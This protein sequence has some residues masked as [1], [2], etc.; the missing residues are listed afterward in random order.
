M[1]FARAHW[2]LLAII[3]E[4]SG[5]LST[6][7]KSILPTFLKKWSRIAICWSGMTDVAVDLKMFYHIVN[8]PWK[9]AVNS[10]T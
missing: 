10:M 9:I 3:E 8:R 2:D 6:R 5:N 4:D 1:C 7:I